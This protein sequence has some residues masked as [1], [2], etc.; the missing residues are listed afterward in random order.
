M[1]FDWRCR[2]GE[3]R[4]EEDLTQNITNREPDKTDPSF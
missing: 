2:V 3:V 1:E 4:R